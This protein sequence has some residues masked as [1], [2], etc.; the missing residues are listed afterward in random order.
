MDT[1]NL[2]QWVIKIAIAGIMALWLYRDARRRDAQWMMWTIMPVLLLFC[3]GLLILIVIIAIP[4]IYIGL[5]PRG[6]LLTCPHCKK[7]ILDELAFCPFC[8][9]SVKRECLKCHHTVPWKAVSCP[10][11]HSTALTDS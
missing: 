9:K 2:I 4:F 10:H 1:G 7:L 11:C 5:R 8:R 3:Q 6:S